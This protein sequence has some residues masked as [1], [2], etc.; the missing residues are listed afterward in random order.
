MLVAENFVNMN[1]SMALDSMAEDFSSVLH[2]AT[3][4]SERESKLVRERERGTG[5]LSL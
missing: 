2:E 1:K 5:E 4:V 3:R